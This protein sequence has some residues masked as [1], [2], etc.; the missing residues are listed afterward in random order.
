VDTEAELR[1]KLAAMLRGGLQTAWQ[2]RAYSGDQIGAVVARLQELA[3][4]DYAGK[5]RAAGFTVTAYYPPEEAELEQGCSTCM[6]YER[7][8]QFCNLPELRLP[9]EAQWSCVMWRI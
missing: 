3:P 7:N 4:Q 8:R 2:L 5:L 1:A 9:V 6:Y